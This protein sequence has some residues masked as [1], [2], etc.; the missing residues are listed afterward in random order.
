MHAAAG[1]KIL[2]LAMAVLAD[3]EHRIGAVGVDDAANLALHDVEGLIPADALELGATA[4]S[5]VD[6]LGISAGLP[7]DAL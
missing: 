2:R 1:M 6:L 5:G 3:G 4:V 7:V